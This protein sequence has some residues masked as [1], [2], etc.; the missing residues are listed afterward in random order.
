MNDLRHGQGHQKWPN[1]ETYEG[2][3]YKDKRHGLGRYTW[4]DGSSY[5]GLFFMNRREGYGSFISQGE[6]KFDVRN[7]YF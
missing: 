5:K 4:P 1:G 3:F 7:F 2:N 6:A